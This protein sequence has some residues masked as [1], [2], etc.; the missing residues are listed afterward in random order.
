MQKIIENNESNNIHQFVTMKIGPQ[1]F[2]I[3]ADYVID[4][5][6]PQKINPIPLTRKEILGSLNLRG[7]IVTALDIRV[8]LEIEDKCDV[9]KNMCVVVEYR[10]ELFSLV[11][12]NVGSVVSVPTDD[13]IHNPENLSEFWKEVSLGIFPFNQDLI[14]VLDIS[15]VLNALMEK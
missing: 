3:A 1:L 12:D 11:V 2:G 10:G 6:M 4:V 8:L 7:R 15:K 13:L 9:E 5:L 14:V